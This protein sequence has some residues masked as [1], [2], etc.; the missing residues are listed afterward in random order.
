MKFISDRDSLDRWVASKSNEALLAYQQ[1]RNA[2]SV[3][4]LLGVRLPSDV[5][6]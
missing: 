4:G 6:E 1:E 2:I 5:A 3:D